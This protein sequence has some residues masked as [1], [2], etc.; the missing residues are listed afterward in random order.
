MAATGADGKDKQELD[1]SVFEKA[2]LISKEA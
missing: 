1:Q 2:D